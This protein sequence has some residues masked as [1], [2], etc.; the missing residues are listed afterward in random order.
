MG[1]REKLLRRMRQNPKGIRFDELCNLL[2]GLGFQRRQSG[3]HVTFTYPGC[4][5]ILT[6]PVKYP[7]IASYGVK[8]ALNLLDELG[9]P[10]NQEGDE[11][12]REERDSEADSRGVDR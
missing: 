7:Y 5:T 8:S 4:R 6:I 10:Q 12:E 9:L 3:S 1:K 11:D 2:L